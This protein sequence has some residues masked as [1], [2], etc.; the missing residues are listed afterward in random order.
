MYVLR[1]NLSTKAY[2]LSK[3][4]TQ[5][6]FYEHISLTYYSLSRLTNFLTSLAYA[7]YLKTAY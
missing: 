5:F 2:F 3:V 1:F 6:E 4:K 7:F